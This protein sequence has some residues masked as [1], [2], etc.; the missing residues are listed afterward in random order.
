MVRLDP[1]TTWEKS[2]YYFSWRRSSPDNLSKA[3]QWPFKWSAKAYEEVENTGG[4]VQGDQA[5]QPA[6]GVFSH[7][8]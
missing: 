2:R 8:M 1:V 6:K 5:R 4:S 7:K 3:K